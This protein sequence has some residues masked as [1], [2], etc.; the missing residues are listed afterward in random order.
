MCY[1]LWIINVHTYTDPAQDLELSLRPLESSLSPGQSHI[2]SC[3][4]PEPAI[5]TWRYNDSLLP[6]NT[7]VIESSGVTSTL[8]INDIVPENAGAYTCRANNTARGVWNEDT[9]Y[10]AS[11]FIL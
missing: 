8:V 10:L 7:E 6:D 2:I 1:I 4:V 9:S 5:F 3:S 11:E